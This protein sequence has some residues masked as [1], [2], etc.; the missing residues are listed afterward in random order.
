MS[1]RP[2]TIL[3]WITLRL[4]FLHL[5]GQIHPRGGRY[6]TW[7][8]SSRL[9]LVR[10]RGRPRLPWTYSF[11]IPVDNFPTVRMDRAPRDVA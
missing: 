5:L 2:N 7:R 4:E 9:T 10:E 1:R 6:S 8:L 11:E 3:S